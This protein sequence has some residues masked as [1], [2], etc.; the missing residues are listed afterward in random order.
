MSWLMGPVYH[1]L[2]GDY[3]DRQHRQRIT[4]RTIQ[5]LQRQGYRVTLEPAASALGRHS[6]DF[7]SSNAR[8]AGD[9]ARFHE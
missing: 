2:G 8:H 9:W 6:R 3:D 4:R 1:E 7:L 5:L